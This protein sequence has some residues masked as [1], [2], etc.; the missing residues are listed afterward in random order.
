MME[1]HDK[2]YIGIHDC[3]V[4]QSTEIHFE[5]FKIFLFFVVVGKKV[6]PHLK[7]NATC[8]QWAILTIFCAISGDFF[9]ILAPNFSHIF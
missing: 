2:K 8:A 6:L 7:V 5:T 4:A 1:C 9:E 3:T